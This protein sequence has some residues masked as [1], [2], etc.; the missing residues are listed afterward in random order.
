MLDVKGITKLTIPIDAE[1]LGGIFCDKRGALYGWIASTN[2]IMRLGS[3]EVTKVEY[4]LPYGVTTQELL[5]VKVDDQ[6]NLYLHFKDNKSPYVYCCDERNNTW[7]LTGMMCHHDTGMW[8]Y[9]YD[10]WFDGQ[11]IFCYFKH[12]DNNIEIY[13]SDKLCQ[14]CNTIINNMTLLSQT[15]TSI[16]DKIYAFV[17]DTE[18][19]NNHVFMFDLGSRR[20]GAMPYVKF[21]IGQMAKA[22]LNLDGQL[23][24]MLN[25]LDTPTTD[26]C[27]KVIRTKPNVVLFRGDMM[28]RAHNSGL[29]I[30]DKGNFYLVQ[31]A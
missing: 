27:L 29:I 15:A 21:K 4:E 1:T 14:M 24:L 22:T 12:G 6:G 23:V 9:M 7:S 20:L 25:F 19:H 13:R 11:L 30:V 10:F 2:I 3:R 18:H 17:E 31:R 16:K 5:N 28:C 26:L 8:N